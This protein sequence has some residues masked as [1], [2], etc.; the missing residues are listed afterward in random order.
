VE[1]T[2]MAVAFVCVRCDD[3]QAI[4]AHSRANCTDRPVVAAARARPGHSSRSRQTDGLVSPPSRPWT[5]GTWS[6]VGVAESGP[7]ALVIAGSKP[8]QTPEVSPRGFTV[9][10]GKHRA[11]RDTSSIFAVAE[12]LEADRRLRAERLAAF[13]E[14]ELEREELPLTASMVPKSRWPEHTAGRRQW[15]ALVAAQ[16]AEYEADRR[17]VEAAAIRELVESWHARELVPAEPAREGVPWW[18]KLRL[19]RPALTG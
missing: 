3:R 1:T 8:P 18:R 5:S 7:P 2:L 14:A 19:F 10:V 16:E 12:Q 9:E 17:R 11:E 15:D 4:A 6:G 13:R